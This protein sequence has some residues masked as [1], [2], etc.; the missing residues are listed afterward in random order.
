M[1]QT[2][3]PRVLPG[4]KIGTTKCMLNV[5]RISLCQVKSGCAYSVEIAKLVYIRPS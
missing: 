5:D 3:I 4:C 1:E 2:S